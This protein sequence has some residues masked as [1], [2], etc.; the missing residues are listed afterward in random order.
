[1]A[2]HKRGCGEVRQLWWLSGHAEDLGPSC[3]HAAM[4][5]T[6][7]KATGMGIPSPA[8]AQPFYGVR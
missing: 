8:G 5:G 2:L 6:V 3:E 1:M 7:S 4:A